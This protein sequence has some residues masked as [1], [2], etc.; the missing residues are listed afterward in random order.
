MLAS[1]FI[2]Q[3][4]LADGWETNETTVYCEHAAIENSLLSFLGYLH[5]RN[6]STRNIET[7]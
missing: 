7:G 4:T 5:T 2:H 1:Q 6:T 3:S